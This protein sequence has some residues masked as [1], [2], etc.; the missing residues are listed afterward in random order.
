VRAALVL[1]AFAVAVVTLVAVG[2][3][4]SVSGVPTPTTFSAT[5]SGSTPTT[6]TTAAGGTATTAP[7]SAPHSH[8][9]ASAS[10][11]T[12]TVPPYTGAKSAV[13]VVVA[14][15][16]STSGLA[17]HF[18]SLVGGSGW[19][20]KTPVNTT[21]P[22]TTSVVYYASGEQAAADAIASAVGVKPSQVLPMASSVPVSGVTGTD[23]VVVIGQDLA[24]AGT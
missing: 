13:S 21:T 11:P 4:P 23:V 14:N 24:S 12:T 9:H 3:R 1:A 17:A 20:M 10:A 18:S 22:Q 16:T 2:T 8:H 7:A 15:G 5:G 6:P 19:S